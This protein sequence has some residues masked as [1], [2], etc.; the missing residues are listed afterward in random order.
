MLEV[1][2]HFEQVAA[3]FS[4]AVLIGAGSAALVVGLFVWLGGLGLRKIL[5]AVAGAVAGGVC[6]FFIT[7][8]NFIL[9]SAAAA[10]GVVIA[11]VFGRVFIIILA[12]ALAAV[13]G[14]AVL[15]GPYI[16]SADSLEQYRVSE[17]QGATEPLSLRQSAETAK[18][19][20]ADFGAAIKQTGL[21]LPVGRWAII[22]GVIV[23]FVTAGLF[24]WRLASAL[25]CSALGTV[26]IFGGMILLLLYKG[27]EPISVICRRGQFY[28]CIFIGM[29]AF[30]T[31]EQ[32]LVCRRRTAKSAAKKQ[33]AK[34]GQG[35]RQRVQTWRTS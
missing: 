1:C 17:A 35:P 2:Q 33:A 31:V 28:L 30:G 22:G 32:L 26:L 23:I 9:A 27:A 4:P 20:T 18:T 29:I 8:G 19:Y 16:G 15:A 3:R 34:D 25:S 12:G 7:G 13:F 10:L 6:G 14:F 5:L 11:V 24:I 21:E